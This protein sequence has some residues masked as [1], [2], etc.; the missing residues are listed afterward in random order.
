MFYARKESHSWARFV[1][2]TELN[3]DYVYIR[4]VWG[5]V[6]KTLYLSRIKLAEVLCVLFKA[7]LSNLNT[8]EPPQPTNGVKLALVVQLSGRTMLAT[9]AT[10][11]RVN[12][13]A[14]LHNLEI[15]LVAYIK[16]TLLS[17]SSSSWWLTSISWCFKIQDYQWRYDRLP[18]VVLTMPTLSFLVLLGKTKCSI[19]ESTVF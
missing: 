19:M 5:R 8:V 13:H 3:R 2:S 6:W 12:V 11:A 4:A 17:I 15:L 1:T 10:K 9:P 7:F 14:G 16:P 18:G